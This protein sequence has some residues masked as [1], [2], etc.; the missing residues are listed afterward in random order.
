MGLSVWDWRVSQAVCDPES[1]ISMWMWIVK[2]TS[3]D[4]ID[5]ALPNINKF[6]HSHNQQRNACQQE[7]PLQ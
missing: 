3:T 6:S 4:N 1:T 2:D 7:F 5:M